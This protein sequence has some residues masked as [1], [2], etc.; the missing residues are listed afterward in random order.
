MK[1]IL[2]NY[3]SLERE[4]YWLEPALSSGQ[5]NKQQPKS[6][7]IGCDMTVNKPSELDNYRISII[8]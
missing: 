6:T 4:G 8:S 1:P 2:F 7:L 3:P 5:L